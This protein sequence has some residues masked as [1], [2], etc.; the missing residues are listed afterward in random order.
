MLYYA[1]YICMYACVYVSPPEINKK[2]KNN[3]KKHKGYEQA[4]HLKGNI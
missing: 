1:E 3:I 2:A 4:F